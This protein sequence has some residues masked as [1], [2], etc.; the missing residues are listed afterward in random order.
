[1]R[2]VRSIAIFILMSGAVSFSSAG[3]L[4]AQE[5]LTLGVH[6]YLAPR[7]LYKRFTPLANYLG[8]QTGQPV[9]IV[10]T[11]DYQEQIDDM[12]ADK[13][14]MAF[15]GPA[16]YIKM[17][18]AYGKKPILACV[19]TNG[20]ATFSGTIIVRQGSP[21][22]KLA[23]LRGKRFAF[24]DR[25]STMGHL[26]PVYVMGK[27]GVTAD[28]L[29]GYEFLGKH[30]NV[31]LGV[32][33]GDFDAGAMRADVLPRYEKRG[34][35][36][37]ARTPEFPEHLLVASNRIPAKKVRALRKALYDMNKSAEGR[38]VLT[39]VK[40]DMTGMVPA[41]DGDYDGLRDIVRQ[42]ERQGIK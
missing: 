17:V 15:M 31:A 22:K 6:P 13:L 14:D 30:E 3:P 38:A 42:L 27:A 7:D 2:I 23:D 37:L 9:R 10:I 19:E 1:M 35:K 26:V 11:Q 20:K 18:D 25:N 24:G 12:G 16:P 8:Q 39:A 29:D 40:E 28:T 34:L 21:L 5:P 36:M 33:S 4:P 32:L 41:A